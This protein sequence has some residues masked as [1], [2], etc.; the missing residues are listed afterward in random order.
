MGAAKGTQL[1]NE[2]VDSVEVNIP[3]LSHS[4]LYSNMVQQ[5]IHSHFSHPT[6]TWRVFPRI[7]PAKKDVTYSTGG[8]FRPVRTRLFALFETRNF[9]FSSR[10][11]NFATFLQEKSKMGAKSNE[12]TRMCVYC[13]DGL[14]SCTHVLVRM[15]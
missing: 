3:A 14:Y 15:R 7:C 4:N 10:S 5:N 2:F 12:F 8:H 13:R 6:R 9:E 1:S 11:K